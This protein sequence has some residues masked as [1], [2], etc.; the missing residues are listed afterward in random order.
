M[1][2]REGMPL[3]G[4]ASYYLNRGG[5]GGFGPGPSVHGP[6]GGS[7]A[8]GLHGPSVFKNPSNSNIS[9]HHP[10]VGGISGNAIGGSSS[11]FH[12][13]NPS[14]NNFHHEMSSMSIVAPSG[15]QGGETV[16]K[17][18]GR[19]RKYG[20]S[21]PLPKI[22]LKLSSPVSGSTTPSTDP[23]SPVDK[24]RR[25][26][27]PGTGWKQKLAPLGDW[28]KTSAG[29]A[30]TP[31]VLQ[32]GV[33]EDV[34][35]KILAFAQQR[36]RALC[37]LSGSGT[38]ST[39]TLRQSTTSADSVTYEGRFEILCLSGSYLVAEASGP[40]NRTGGISISMCSPDGHMIGGAIGGR[41]IA[42]NHVQ[43]VACSFVYDGSKGKTKPEPGTDEKYLLEQSTEKPYTPF[44]AAS[45]Q[46]LTPN[47]GPSA[48]SLSSR[49][50]VKNSQAEIDLTRG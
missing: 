25:G 44:S 28:M 7:G 18:R 27:P 13:G 30:F 6:G 33:G 21:G 50:D 10:N 1:D 47:S 29:L 14:H 48:W 36:P 32:I 37:V 26:R 9:M 42:A 24:R 23:I 8:P 31:H 4:S 40:R 41:L 22:T 11:A 17:K 49:L 38:V 2:G 20:P 16:K 19:P 15:P 34:A 12:V 39:V 45:T 35:E 5:I 43:V 3:Q 46:T